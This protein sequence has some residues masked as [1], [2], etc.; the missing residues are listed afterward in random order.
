MIVIKTPVVAP[1]LRLSIPLGE[2][3]IASAYLWFL[4]PGKTFQQRT[5]PKGYLDEVFVES[6]FRGQLYGTALLEEAVDLA[7]QRC[8]KSFATS[9]HSN[10]VAHKIYEDKLGFTNHGLEFRIDFE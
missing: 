4:P 1:G 2:V 5:R 7:Y 8:Y 6:G 10:P 3:E 9:R